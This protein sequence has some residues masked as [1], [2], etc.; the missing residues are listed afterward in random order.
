MSNPSIIGLSVTAG[1]ANAIALSQTPGG[2]GNLT[3]N[4]ASVSGG[5]ATLSGAVLQYGT[6]NNSP[7]S[8]KQNGRRVVIASTGNDAT[9]VFTITGTDLNGRVITDTI[10]GLNISTGVSN[11]DFL[12]VTQ[13][14]A[15]A[16]TAGAITAGTNNTASTPWNVD[17]FLAQFWALSVGCKLAS[18]AATYS[19]DH[20]YDDP[21]TSGLASSI[22]PGSN[23]PPLVFNLAALNAK[24]ASA[25]GQYVDQPIF[26]HRLTISAGQGVIVMQSIQAGMGHR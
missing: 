12:T 5:V 15:S 14:A 21:N 13:I 9:V 1:S 4:G 16:G 19:V 22:E 24:S 26:A 23:I 25:E 2:A 7:L 11:Y 17:N 18:G 3:L 8:T 6:G 20:T 10:T